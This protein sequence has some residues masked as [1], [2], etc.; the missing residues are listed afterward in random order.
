MKSQ[1]KHDDI[2]MGLGHLSSLA[3]ELY[4]K[5][6]CCNEHTEIASA[7]E[8]VAYLAWLLARVSKTVQ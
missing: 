1:I 3:S 7:A 8:R 6:Q 4:E 2:E 5:A